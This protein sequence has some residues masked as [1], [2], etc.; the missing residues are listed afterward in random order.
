MAINFRVVR[1]KNFLSTGNAFTELQLD[2]APTTLVVGEN[3]SGKSTMLDAICFALFGRP[4]RKINKPQLLNAINTKACV[5]EIEFDIGA[6]SYKVIRGMRPGVFEI[7]QNG[8]LI[9]QD[10]AKRD[11]QKYL[12]ESILKLNYRSFTQISILGSASFVPFMQLTQGQRRE[13]IEDILDIQIFTVMN[14]VLKDKLQDMKGRL[15]DVET[16]L[17]L[18]VGKAKM[19]EEYIKTLQ[20]DHTERLEEIARKIAETEQ[21][22]KETEAT[23]VALTEKRDELSAAIADLS[24]VKEQRQAIYTDQLQHGTLIQTLEEEIAFYENNVECPTCKQG[25]DDEFR[26]GTLIKKRSAHHDHKCYVD[27]LQIDHD[28]LIARLQEINKVQSQISDVDMEVNSENAKIIADQ[29]YVQTLLL[30]KHDLQT[31][32]GNIAAEKAKLKDLAKVVVAT[33]KRR[34]S[35]NEERHYLEIAGSLLKDSGI[36]TKIIRKYLPAINKLVNKYLQAMDFFVQFN[37]D[38]QF[39]ESIKSR[40]RDDF[41][42]ESFS[43]GEKQ[44]IDLAL[45]FTWRTIAK[46]KNS[47][48]TNL[49][50]L[51]EVFD[52][53]LDSN[54]TDYVMSLLHTLGEDTH[55]WV[56][57]HKG[58][59][60]FDKFTQVLRFEKKQNFSVLTT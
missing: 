16:D 35:L 28:K 33:S 60:L 31:K 23:I 52:S 44:R 24:V 30:E 22:V 6:K 26:E 57:S 32:G 50:L 12:E 47:A 59:Q 20:A 36:K 15:Q 4:F 53:S 29:R 9:D 13:I 48:S 19:Q 51:D 3:G 18:A 21:Q 58:D 39:N 55:C 7:Y 11:Y 46:L 43:E 2:A 27:T 25:I 49:L 40:H 8:V 38:E 42:Y 34:T 14:Q 41:S 45:V 17:K 5:V 37:L 10:A 56:I 1:W 54:G